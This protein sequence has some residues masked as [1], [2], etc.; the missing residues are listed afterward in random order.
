MKP[1]PLT[2]LEEYLLCEDRPGYPGWICSRLRFHGTLQRDVLARAFAAAVARHPLARAVVRRGRFGRPAW[3]WPEGVGPLPVDWRARAADGGWPEFPS[4][5]L[6]A[7]PGFRLV[8]AEEAAITEVYVQSH[9]AVMDGAGGFGLIEE[10]LLHYAHELGVGVGPRVL[11][12][13]RLTHRGRLAASWAQLL[14][15]LPGLALG[16]ALNWQLARRTV[17]PLAAGKFSTPHPPPAVVRLTLT[18]ADYQ[19]LRAGARRAGAGVND[20]LLRDLFAAIRAWRDARGVVAPLDW[21]RLAVPVSLRTRADVALP[22]A[23]GFGMVALDRRAKSLANRER[24]LRRA[25]EDMDMVKQWRLGLTFPALLALRRRWPGGI[26]AYSAHPVTRATAVLTNDGKIFAH[27]PFLNAA[28][29]VALP[30]AVLED[31]AVSLPCR[32]GTAA[33]VAV[34][35]YAGTMF[36]DLTYDSHTL[37]ADQAG[38]LLGAFEAQLRLTMDAETG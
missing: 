33:L 2:P 24:L 7:A 23:N 32:P 36:A 28:R 35:V 29:R 12:P 38:K 25:R 20:V 18:A 16:L 6:E 26:A 34:G 19:R 13:E 5:G 37:T 1:L 30:G 14:A 15:R 17:A 31:V 8:V 9:H 21:I 4:H 3:M 10:I 22:A 11:K 27:S